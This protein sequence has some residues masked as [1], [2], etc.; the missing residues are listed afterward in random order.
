MKDEMLSAELISVFNQKVL[1]VYSRQD[2]IVQIIDP[3]VLAWYRERDDRP[4]FV[5]K[6]IC[7]ARISGCKYFTHVMGLLARNPNLPN[8]DKWRPYLV[9]DINFNWLEYLSKPPTSE[10]AFLAF[11]LFFSKFPK[12]GWERYD[13]FERIRA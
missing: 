4:L 12:P 11:H 8:K 9:T 3:M 10:D 2:Q 6:A 13:A 7:A 5:D 1:D